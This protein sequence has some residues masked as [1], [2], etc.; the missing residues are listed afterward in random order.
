MKLEFN[1]TEHLSRSFDAITTEKNINKNIFLEESIIELLKKHN[2]YIIDKRY[3]LI[4]DETYIVNVLYEENNTYILSDGSKIIKRLFEQL[5]KEYNGVDPNEFFNSSI[6]VFD[7]LISKIVNEEKEIERDV[8]TVD[9]KDF[10]DST[11]LNLTDFQKF[12]L[13]EIKSKPLKFN[14]FES[15]DD[16]IRK[17]MVKILGIKKLVDS[18]EYY[19][20]NKEELKK[21]IGELS[22]IK[23]MDN[24]NSVLINSLYKDLI[25]FYILLD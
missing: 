10:F 11:Q 15:D 3:S 19:S 2:L 18:K 23:F 4:T 16:L 21:I 22:D 8:K 25:S 6:N 7:T 13:N 20:K 17:K 5:F 9:P 14:D 12:N 1:I 24:S